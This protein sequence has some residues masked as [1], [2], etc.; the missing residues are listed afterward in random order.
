MSSKASK[1][2][3]IVALAVIVLLIAVVTLHVPFGAGGGEY[4]IGKNGDYVICGGERYVPAGEG[5][6]ADSRTSRVIAET[7]PIEGGDLLDRY[8]IYGY[9]IYGT[10]DDS[11]IYVHTVESADSAAGYY[12]RESLANE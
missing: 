6:T 10:S 1:R 2:F 8:F 4:L 7:V 11:V 9:V 3:F 5:Y 12:V